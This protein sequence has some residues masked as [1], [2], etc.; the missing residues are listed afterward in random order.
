[1]EDIGYHNED[2]IAW[3]KS[4]YNSFVRG[5]GKKPDVAEVLVQWKEDG[6]NDIC[7][8]A[9]N[10]EKENF[11]NNNV[12]F[13]CNDIDEFFALMK[14]DN[15]EDFII[16]DI[17]SFSIM[18]G[19]VQELKAVE[20][21]DSTDDCM[22]LVLH[23]KDGEQIVLNTDKE[24]V[25]VDAE[26]EWMKSLHIA[27]IIGRNNCKIA[28]SLKPF[29]IYNLETNQIEQPAVITDI[30]LYNQSAYPYERPKIRCKINGEQ[31]L[32]RN[33]PIFEYRRIM[34]SKKM[35]QREQLK[36]GLVYSLFRDVLNKNVIEHLNGKQEKIIGIK[37]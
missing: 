25:I 18:E 21:M 12:M 36:M 26:D 20:R 29:E 28:K 2:I 7:F 11:L 32:W 37:R 22:L 8:I 4:R 6:E 14:E 9:L 33:V 30:R 31:Q 24:G 15:G 13:V 19:K 35:E 17:M 1:M 3:N 34:F 23:K 27:E 10:K 16:K 5:V